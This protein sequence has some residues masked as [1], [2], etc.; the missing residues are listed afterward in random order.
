MPSFSSTRSLILSTCNKKNYDA[1]IISLHKS[2][3]LYAVSNHLSCKDKLNWITKK[4]ITITSQCYLIS[5]HYWSLGRSQNL[6]ENWS[7]FVGQMPF[8]SLN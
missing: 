3:K 1:A 7:S 5:L 2:A 6:W 8:L 4:A